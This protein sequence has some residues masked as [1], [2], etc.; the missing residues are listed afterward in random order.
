MES[1]QDALK[2]LLRHYHDL[3]QP[4]KVIAELRWFRELLSHGQSELEAQRTLLDHA[5]HALAARDLSAADLLRERYKEGLKAEYVASRLGVAQATLFEWQNTAVAKLANLVQQHEAEECRRHVH[6]L[7]QRL[8]LAATDHLVGIEPSTQALTRLLQDPTAPWLVAITGIGGIGKTTLAASTALAT[9]KADVWDKVA[10]VMAR[11]SFFESGWSAAEDPQLTTEAL[12]E[13][14]YDQLMP[15]EPKPVTFSDHRVLFRLSETCRRQ[16]CLIVVDN[17]ESV[18]ATRPLL[19]ALRQL[20]KPSKVLIGTRE[21]IYMEVDVAEF[22]VP[23]LDEA[24]A[25][26]LLRASAAYHIDPADAT[27]DA[28]RQVYAVAGGNPQALRM[29]AGQLASFSLEDVIADLRNIRSRRVEQLYDHIYR[30]AWDGLAAAER[31]V[32]LTV[33]AVDAGGETLDYII[34]LADLGERPVHDAIETLVVRNLVERR[35]QGRVV[36]YALHNLTRTFLYQQVV[37]WQ[38]GDTGV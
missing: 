13:Q 22:A 7:Q 25:L 18:E 23:E 1:L 12:L 10:W 20:V 33:A 14:L 32:L 8:P 2:L 31:H 30:R 38:D 36:R 34:R 9:V 21:K 17:L 5:L 16:R 27:D 37:R 19:P 3:E 26:A 15:G 6:N 4:P 24:D 28:L 29:V 11:T 35:R